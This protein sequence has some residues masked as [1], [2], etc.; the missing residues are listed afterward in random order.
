MRIY[1]YI[2]IYTHIY[3]STDR[4][5]V[6][7]A[8][9]YRLTEEECMLARQPSPSEPVKVAPYEYDGSLQW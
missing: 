2:Y 4:R 8:V 9:C 5:N 6:V 1:I 7:F 3:F